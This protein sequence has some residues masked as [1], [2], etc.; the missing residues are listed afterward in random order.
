MPCSLLSLSRCVSRNGA[1]SIA[2][3]REREAALAILGPEILKDESC[4]PGAGAG[5][6]FHTALLS[7]LFSFIIMYVYYSNS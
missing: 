5:Q 1:K 6:I 4:L 3:G 2:D 7:H